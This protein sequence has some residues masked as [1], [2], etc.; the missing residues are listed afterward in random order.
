MLSVSSFVTLHE[1]ADKSGIEIKNVDTTT[2]QT[3]DLYVTL[4]NGI[5]TQLVY[6]LLL[7]QSCAITGITYTHDTSLVVSKAV[8]LNHDTIV[9]F[10]QFVPTP[11][12]VCSW[13]SYQI[14]SSAAGTTVNYPLQGAT[15]STNLDCLEFNYNPGAVASTT[16]TIT[17]LKHAD[18]SL[19]AGAVFSYTFTITAPYDCNVAYTYQYTPD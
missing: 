7:V 4:N 17:V 10:T 6:H 13:T 12:N 2:P 19:V 11:N 3:Q 1:L 8:S 5:N 15:C 14:T 18:A 9:S 16:I